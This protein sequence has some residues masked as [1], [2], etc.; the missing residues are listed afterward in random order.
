MAEEITELTRTEISP[1]KRQNRKRTSAKQKKRVKASVAG[2][3][4][5][6]PLAFPKHPILKCLRIPQAVLENNAGKVCT[7]REA[8]TFAGVG[9]GGPTQVEIS[10]AIKYGLFQRPSPGKV[11]PTDI[12]RRI[13]RP[14]KP[15]DEIGAIRE[16][17][18]NAPIISDVYK[19]YRG[20][21]LPDEVSFLANTVTDSFKIPADKVNEFISVFLEDLEAAQL[22]EEANGKK[23][24]LDITHEP[25]E[26]SGVASVTLDNH[27]K[28]VSKG[29]TKR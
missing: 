20:E 5:G 19:H 28:K 26:A 27:L 8:A 14:Q 25:P 1:A 21:N 24:V 22:I 29:V 12:T 17:V 11:E 9:W 4:R 15:A 2:G 7:D 16:A 10:S 6:T 13:V 18:L 3:Q 23:R